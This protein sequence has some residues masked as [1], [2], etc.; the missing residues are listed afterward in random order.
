MPMQSRTRWV[1]LLS[2]V[3]L[4]PVVAALALMLW[5]SATTEKLLP[6]LNAADV[7]R[8]EILRL[9][10][11][12]AGRPL[13]LERIPLSTPGPGGWRI[14]STANAPADGK[15]VE[16]LLRNLSDLR[17]RRQDGEAGLG[18]SRLEVRL[19]NRRGHP[20]G[21][22]AFRDDRAM[23]L[24]EAGKTGPMLAIS[25]LP[26]L[27]DWPSGWTTLEAPRIDVARIVAV[28]RPGVDGPERLS[29]AAVG[30]TAKV[31][32]G[33]DAQDFMAGSDVRWMGAKLLR[34][35]LDD[36]STVDLQQVPDGEGR[37]FLRMTSDRIAAVR[38]S[39]RFAFRVERPLP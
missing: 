10:D 22:A 20:L 38:D 1:A 3:L 18:P 4:A 5:R 24:P 17:G 2:L 15:R 25:G 7:T 33:L 32:L 9:E 8:V 6:E 34:V 19:F 13:V 29:P 14:A 36:G 30:Q 37:Y 27:P 21:A 12:R 35:T 26:A 23:R 16:T 11:G 28:E 39:R 31:L